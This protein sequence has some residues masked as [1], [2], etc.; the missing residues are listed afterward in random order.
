MLPP[1][2]ITSLKSMIEHYYDLKCHYKRDMAY[3]HGTRTQI[4]RYNSK[5]SKFYPKSSRPIDFFLFMRVQPFFYKDT[6]LLFH[7]SHVCNLQ[8]F[9]FRKFQ[10]SYILNLISYLLKI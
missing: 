4:G 3:A 6:R 10:L 1:L 7:Q 2:K 5:L 8:R 9:N